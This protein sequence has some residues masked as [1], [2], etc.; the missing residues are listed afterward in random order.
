M[1]TKNALKQVRTPSIQTLRDEL[2]LKSHLFDAETKEQWKK[3]EKDWQ[4][5]RSELQRLVPQA[6]RAMVRS[7]L[8]SRP[9]LTKIHESLERVQ[10]GLGRHHSD[11]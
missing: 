6:K 3:F 8:A 1:K 10:E 2:K 11:R 5:I 7:A 9:L 4:L